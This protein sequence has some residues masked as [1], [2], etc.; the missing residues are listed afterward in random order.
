MCRMNL[1]WLLTDQM[2][3]AKV[4]IG[5]YFAN[6]ILLQIQLWKFRNT[7]VLTDWYIEYVLANVL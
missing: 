2:N 4:W 6:F 3:N 5:I 1:I 7:P